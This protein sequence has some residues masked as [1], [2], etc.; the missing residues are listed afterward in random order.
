M[1]RFSSPPSHDARRRA[2]AHLTR[3]A[4]RGRQPR[5][6]VAPGLDLD[7][8]L[9]AYASGREVASIVWKLALRDGG[10]LGPVRFEN[11]LRRLSIDPEL[12]VPFADAMVRAGL[13]QRGQGP[14]QW[15]ARSSR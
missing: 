6:A 7:A 9:G 10:W 11:W 15:R 4:H 13:F 3:E 5:P 8:P 12:A 2:A 1:P 14:E